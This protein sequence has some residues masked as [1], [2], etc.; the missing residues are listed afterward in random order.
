MTVPAADEMINLD[1]D[2]DMF[3]VAKGEGY[4]IVE[5]WD[6]VDDS[7]WWTITM[8]LGAKPS[9]LR[10]A[11]DWFTDGVEVIDSYEGDGCL[12]IDLGVRR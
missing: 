5:C 3:V 2:Y 10:D 11:F 7:R 12:Y 4:S 6:S 9:K 8:D 1:D